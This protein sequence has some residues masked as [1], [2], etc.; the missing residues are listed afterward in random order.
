MRFLRLLLV[1]L[2]AL[3]DTGWAIYKRY[4]SGSSEDTPQKISIVAH[5]SGAIAGLLVGI[6]VLK[7]RKVH[8]WEIRLKIL[9]IIT[10]ALFIATCIFWNFTADSLMYPEKFF[11]NSK[12]HYNECTYISM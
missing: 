12:E 9:C 3:I 1:I 10:F 6:I 2:Y 11:E 5:L 7:N 8:T 4:N